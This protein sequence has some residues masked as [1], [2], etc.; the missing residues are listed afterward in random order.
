MV[1]TITNTL[2][3]TKDIEAPLGHVYHAF[4]TKAGWLEWFAQKGDGHVS[5]DTVMF[6]YTEGSG[7]YVLHF[8]ELN[9]KNLV[10]FTLI[11]LDSY[12]NAKVRVEMQQNGDQTAVTLAV[13]TDDGELAAKLQDLWEESLTNLKSVV[14]TGK[15]LTLWNRPFLGINVEDWVTPE[16]AEEKGLSTEY[17][18]LLS[19][20]FEGRGADKAG[21]SGHDIIVKLDNVEIVDYDVLLDVFSQHKAGDTI[22]VEFYHG[23]EL[24]QSLITLSQYPVPEIPAN[25]QDIANKF[26]EFFGKVNHMVDQTLEGQTEAQLE[27][28]PDGGEWSAKEIL[29]H[30]TANLTDSIEWL[31]GYIAGRPIYAYTSTIPARLKTLL[32]LYPTTEE[33]LEAFRRNQQELI[34]L[35]ENIPAE[36][37]SRKSSLGRIS[38]A[39]IT[40]YSNFYKKQLVQLKETL[41][42]AADVRGS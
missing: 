6:L 28:R 9:K 16:L 33:L 30:L 32:T 29:A 41:Q 24:K 42:K 12:K 34:V 3:F 22:P 5:K 27:Y 20:V 7:S 39:A 21:I 36:V 2:T 31:S 13:D 35:M 14:E 40:D 8:K 1:E 11:D 37:S 25:T 38:S 19:S 17:G 10:T 26:K 23:S 15:D 18:L 4:G